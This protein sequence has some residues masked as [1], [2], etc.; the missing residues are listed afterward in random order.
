MQN[1]ITREWMSIE[2]LETE[3]KNIVK[4]Y[5]DK[6]EKLIKILAE[7]NLGD[8]TTQEVNLINASRVDLRAAL[9]PIKVTPTKATLKIRDFEE[10]IKTIS[11][12][13]I[14]YD[15]I[16]IIIKELYTFYDKLSEFYINGRS[17][18]IGTE[19]VNFGE[20]IINKINELK[21]RFAYTNKLDIFLEGSV[22]Y[23]ED[24]I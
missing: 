13:N 1:E 6:E 10:R 15:E 8:V 5:K 19:L 4:C 7:N 17:F 2:G 16:N 11:K 14:F 20:E 24:E 18:S 23:S 9:N 22:E 21:D 12:N 3:I